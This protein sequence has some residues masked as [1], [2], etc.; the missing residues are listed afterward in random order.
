MKWGGVVFEESHPFGRL[1]KGNKE[2]ISFV[3]S[4]PSKY[5]SNLGFDTLVSAARVLAGGV[6]DVNHQVSALELKRP[7]V[8]IP[9]P[10]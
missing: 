3:C 9:Y 2:M 7:G 6:R 1:S 5:F 8:K 4:L 10:R